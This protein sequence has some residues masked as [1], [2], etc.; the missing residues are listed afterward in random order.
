MLRFYKNSISPNM[1]SSCRYLP[2]CSEYSMMSY[3]QF[4]ECVSLCSKIDVLQAL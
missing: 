2:T 4:G 1:A 3:K